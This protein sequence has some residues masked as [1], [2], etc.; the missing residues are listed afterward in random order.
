[1]K[2]LILAATLGI[3][4]TTIFA[5]K[6][7]PIQYGE[8]EPMGSQAQQTPVAEYRNLTLTKYKNER[9]MNLSLFSEYSSYEADLDGGDTIKLDGFALGVSSNP[10]N[11][12]WYGKFETLKDDA[13]DADYYELSFGGQINLY[14]YQG[15]YTA[16]T[17]GFG[18]AWA[19]SSLLANDVNFMTIPIGLEIG[20]SLVPNLSIYG[21]VGYKWL[22]DTTA[23]TTCKDGSTSNSV[24]SGTCSSHDGIDRYNDYVGDN[25]GVTYK[26]G[27]RY[28]F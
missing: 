8:P 22:I 14:S 5:D 20:Y 17:L 12:G 7:L 6:P 15:F 27:L 1:M 21:G 13:L 18:Y 23:S 9:E 11:N 2:K 26:A 19:E 16:G 28:N 4:S 25:N 24:G 3:F 10:H